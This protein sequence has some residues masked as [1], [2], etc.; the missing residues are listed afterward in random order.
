MELFSIRIQRT[1]QLV[2]TNDRIMDE[3]DFPEYGRQC[4]LKTPWRGY[5]R[6]TIVALSEHGF[7]VQFSSGAE[8]DVYKDE[9]IFD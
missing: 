8:I 3:Y 6:G 7:V 2:S 5:H 1:F 4:E 9:I